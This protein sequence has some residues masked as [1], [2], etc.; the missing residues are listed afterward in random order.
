MDKMITG[1]KGTTI[2]NDGATILNLL[3]IEHPAARIL[4]DI[5]KAQDDEV[6]DGTT[7]VVLL[8]GEMLNQSKNFIEEGMHPQII[9]EGYRV[10]LR[11]A[12]EKLN[13][14]SVGLELDNPEYTRQGLLTVYQEEARDA[15]EVRADLA[16]LKATGEL[17]GPVRRAG[18]AGGGVPRD[19][20]PRQGSDWDQAYQRR[21]GVGKATLYC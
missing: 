21:L 17:P 7:S 14:L 9:I 8:A 16:E 15:Q 20:P 19:K 5:G 3:E 13:E 4:V 12:L 10:A 2:T 6:G 1:G 11:L 18:R